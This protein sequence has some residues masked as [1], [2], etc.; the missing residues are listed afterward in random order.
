MDKFEK[1]FQDFEKFLDSQCVLDYNDYEGYV[2]LDCNYL[3]Q[4]T[5]SVLN[6]LHKINNINLVVERTMVND[7]DYL[8]V[9]FTEKAFEYITDKRYG[10][11]E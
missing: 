10:S 1:A 9:Y 5:S 3:G 6:K 11:E 4:T 7:F 8:D 2:T